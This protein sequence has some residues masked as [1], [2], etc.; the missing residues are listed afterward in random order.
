MVMRSR[1]RFA[2]ATRRAL[3]AQTIWL[4]AAIYVLCT[5]AAQAHFDPPISPQVTGRSSLRKCL[6]ELRSNTRDLLPTDFDTIRRGRALLRDLTAF[7]NHL[8]TRDGAT[9][10][11]KPSASDF[12]RDSSEKL[13]WLSLDYRW[14]HTLRDLSQPIKSRDPGTLDLLR[15]QAILD[16]ARQLST[17]AL[18][19]GSL[20]ATRSDRPRSLWLSMFAPPLLEVVELL[21]EQEPNAAMALD[22]L[23]DESMQAM[24]RFRDR[25]P[26]YPA[27]NGDAD[28]WLTRMNALQSLAVPPGQ[29]SEAIDLKAAA[30]WVEIFTELGLAAV[31]LDQ[32]ADALAL[33]LALLALGAEERALELMRLANVPWELTVE[34]LSRYAPELP[35][36]EASERA[37]GVLS[38]HQL[39]ALKR[40][41]LELD[42]LRLR[43]ARESVVGSDVGT[44][45]VRSQLL[46]LS[47]QLNQAQ[48]ETEPTRRE[49]LRNA[50][51]Q[52]LSPELVLSVDIADDYRANSLLLWILV[53]LDRPGDREFVNDLTLRRLAFEANK[54]KERA[55]ARLRS[56][57]ASGGALGQE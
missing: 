20:P 36:A 24:S 45:L 42:P 56:Q 52:K 35:W 34:Q 47:Q 51:S 40:M 25:R 23:F 1:R 43:N 8:A 44:D 10:P 54:I 32:P 18:M 3:G 48:H 33:S 4:P 22:E 46:R 9:D 53:T 29:A 15:L 37:E 6:V 2:F 19:I 27:K 7:E 16:S 41:L 49:E 13:L 21:A 55:R 11:S 26:P 38:L 17:L 31:W 39:A 30:L 57:S 5:G 12:S 14:R 50:V 28:L